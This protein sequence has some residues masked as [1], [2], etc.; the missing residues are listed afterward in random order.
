M[1]LRTSRVRRQSKCLWLS[2]FALLCSGALAQAKDRK[3][4]PAEVSEVKETQVESETALYRSSQPSGTMSAPPLPAGSEK[5][6][7]MV[8][9]Y[10]FKTEAKQIE[11]VVEKKPVEGLTKGLKVQIFVQRGWI[12][13]QM[14]DGKEKRMDLVP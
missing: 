3:W 11:G 6:K 10:V 1:L 12:I 7:K 13:V 9:N 2:V 8:Y 14:P 5:R 4:I